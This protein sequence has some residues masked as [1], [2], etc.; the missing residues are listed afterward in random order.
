MIGS[1][2]NGNTPTFANGVRFPTGN[3]FGP[4]EGLALGT[5]T[6]LSGTSVTFGY[7]STPTNNE[8]RFTPAASVP[9]VAGT[10]FLLGTLSFTN[11][12]WYGAHP[13]DPALNVPS[14]FDFRLETTS[15]TDAQFNQ[16]FEGSVVLAVH[17]N[18]SA[19]WSTLAGQQAEADWLYLTGQNTSGAGAALGVQQ[20]TNAFRVY[21]GFAAPSGVSNTGTVE[22]WA[23]FGSL[24]LLDFR[25]PTGGGFVT[26]SIAPLD[27]QIGAGPVTPVPEPASLLLLASGLSAC[28][29]ACMRRRTS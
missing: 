8:I 10:P 21:D 3:N 4:D 2:V 24:T 22:L 17:S 23:Q 14:Y 28:A 9:G 5:L 11:G 18:S 20:T 12:A 1:F 6:G 25:R 15:S 13:S 19:N 16:T 29:A 27:P 7:A 26:G